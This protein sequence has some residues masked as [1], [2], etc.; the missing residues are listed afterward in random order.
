MVQNEVLSS[1]DLQNQLKDQLDIQLQKMRDMNA[2]EMEAFVVTL[3]QHFDELLSPYLD[4]SIPLSQSHQNSIQSFVGSAVASLQ[5]T[6][7]KT[8]GSTSEV[9]GNTSSQK[10]YEVLKR[11]VDDEKSRTMFFEN[12]WRSPMITNPYRAVPLQY[13]LRHIFGDTPIRGVDLGAGLHLALPLLNSPEFLD[14]DFPGKGELTTLVNRPVSIELGIGVDKQPRDLDWVIASSWPSPESAAA[15][16]EITPK[17][18]QH[19]LKVHDQFPFLQAD[20]TD[21]GVGSRILEIANGKLLEFVFTSFVRPQLAPSVQ[22]NFKGLVGSLLHDGGI[23]VDIGE[24][25]MHGS[26]SNFKMSAVNVYQKN[27]GELDFIGKPFTLERQQLISGVD[28]AFFDKRVDQ[29]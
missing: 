4:W 20:I 13:I 3:Q 23:W 29:R 8:S 26:S 17:W 6:L 19:A 24:E 5:Y 9:I 11:I 22:D 15:T 21:P 12:I 1:T 28:K 16:K 7:V 10:W 2:P 27:H 25:L 14:R 18:L